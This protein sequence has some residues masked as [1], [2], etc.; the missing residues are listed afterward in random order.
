MKNM[1]GGNAALE[2]QSASGRPKRE[3]EYVKRFSEKSI[4]AEIMKIY[5]IS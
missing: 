4:A 3:K 5:G 2:G 1:K